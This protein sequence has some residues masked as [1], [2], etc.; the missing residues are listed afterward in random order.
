MVCDFGH[1]HHVPGPE[2]IRVVLWML[3]PLGDGPDLFSL[4]RVRGV[5]SASRAEAN[6]S[7]LEVSFEVMGGLIYLTDSYSCS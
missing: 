2:L 3:P 7:S 6:T 5:A 1:E 4:N